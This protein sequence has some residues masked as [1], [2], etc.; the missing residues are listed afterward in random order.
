M[1][2]ADGSVGH[3]YDPR[4]GLRRVFERFRS[5]LGDGAVLVISNDPPWSGDDDV[6][7]HPDLTYWFLSQ[8]YVHR[9]VEACGFRDVTSTVF[10]SQKPETGPRDRVVVTGRV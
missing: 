7:K 5:W 1:L 6:Q 2:Y 9:E 10:T 4:I 8:S 3:L